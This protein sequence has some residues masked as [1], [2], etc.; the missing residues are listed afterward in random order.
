[1]SFFQEEI[2]EVFY[3]SCDLIPVQIIAD[4]C[5]K[6]SDEFIVELIEQLSSEMNP[7]LVCATAGKCKKIL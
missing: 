2:K 5:K 3:G 7:D 6:L 4:E 1:M